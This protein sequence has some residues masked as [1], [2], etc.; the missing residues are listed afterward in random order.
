MPSIAPTLNGPLGCGSYTVRLVNDGAPILQTKRVTTVLWTRRIDEASTATVTIPVSG[1][2]LRACCDGVNRIEPLRTEVI[3]DR[4]GRPVWQG[5]IM[6]D[7]EIQRDAIIVNAHD[8]LAWTERRVLNLDH[9]DVGVDLTD[10]A[11]GYIADVNSAGDLP[12]VITSSPTGITADRTVLTTEYQFAWEPL[13]SLLESGLDATVIAGHLLLGAETAICGTLQL[14]DTD[15]DGSP[16]LRMDGAQR[17]TRVIVKGGTNEDGGDQ[18][19]AIYPS[20]PPDVCFHA[21]DYILEDEEILDQN[22]A[23]AAAEELYQRLSSSYPYYLGIPEGSGL[24]PHA[25]VDINGLIPGA[26]IQFYSQTLC[27]DVGM[28]MRLVGLD[29][30]V[31]SG[32]ES[33]R[34]VLEPIG[35]NEVLPDAAA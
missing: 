34:I 12:F 33:V 18:V 15:V 4:D 35:D 20:E 5:W 26:I 11:L 24:N 30:E 6:S 16:E 28:A 3:I 1:T 8:I 21:A 10:I 2:D 19:I 17:A 29:V 22:S 27:L 9:V 13:Q 31:T 25:P 14:R 32:V 23:D 7:I